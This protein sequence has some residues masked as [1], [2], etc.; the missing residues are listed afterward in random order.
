M[1]SRTNKMGI[2]KQKKQAEKQK[3]LIWENNKTN[4]Q[5]QKREYINPKWN[6]YN[7]FFRNG[8][9][10]CD[11]TSAR[12]DPDWYRIVRQPN[13]WQINFIYKWNESWSYRRYIKKNRKYR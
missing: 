10:I 6:V 8:K 11:N 9:L 12:E 3:K 4:L 13:S 5:W 2:M 7:W 1:A